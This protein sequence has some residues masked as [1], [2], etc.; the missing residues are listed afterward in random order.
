MTAELNTAEL[1]AVD[2]TEFLQA[3]SIVWFPR[4]YKVHGR[5]L[6]RLNV[7]LSKLGYVAGNKPSA[8]IELV[9]AY[10]REF[11]PAAFCTLFNIARQLEVKA[12]R[13]LDLDQEK[14]TRL[15]S[16]NPDWKANISYK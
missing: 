12:I 8:L 7:L 14:H 3:E 1:T 10:R 6:H 5:E 2:P 13:G 9:R 15:F 4:A 16:H 11:S